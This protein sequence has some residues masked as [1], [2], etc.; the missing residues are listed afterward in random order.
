E[1]DDQ[2]LQEAA[3]VRVVL[4]PICAC[5]LFPSGCGSV[6]GQFAVSESKCLERGVKEVVKG[7]RLGNKLQRNR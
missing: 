1:A 5:G 7:I 2:A 4:R 6:L 3:R